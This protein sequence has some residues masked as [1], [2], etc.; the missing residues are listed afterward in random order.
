[1][2]R[3]RLRHLADLDAEER[4][5]VVRAVIELALTDAALRTLGYRRL[6]AS[7]GLDRPIEH[8]PVDDPAEV[9][10]ARRYARVVSL[11]A[12]HHVVRANCLHEAIVLHRWLRAAGLPSD[13][14][15]GVRKDRAALKAHAWVELDGGILGQPAK[16]VMPF[17][18]LTPIEGTRLATLGPWTGPPAESVAGYAVAQ[19]L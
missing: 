14:R 19:G 13:L 4:W 10:L 7:L 12:R 18:V 17:S 9:R 5:L 3:R 2:L 6:M 1:M 15:I 8:R 16:A 11:A